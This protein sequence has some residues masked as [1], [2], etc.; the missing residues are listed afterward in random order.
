MITFLEGLPGS[1]KS[2][3]SVVHRLI[4]ALLE[5]REIVTNVDGINHAQISEL[6]GI[7]EKMLKKMIHL[8]DGEQVIELDKHF[9]PNALH[10][11]DELQNYFPA[12]R[13]P[14]TPGLSDFVTK[15]RHHGIDLVCMGQDYRDCHAL[16][17]RRIEIKMQ[18]LQLG[19]VGKPDSYKWTSYRA[20]GKG[21]SDLQFDKIQS[22]VRK[23]DPAY[24][25][26][27]ASYVSEDTNTETYTDARVNL[28][29]NKGLRYGVPGALLVSAWAFVHLLGF[30]GLD[31]ADESIS[32][33]LDDAK[34][35]AQLDTPRIRL[36]EFTD[37]VA[38]AKAFIMPEPPKPEYKDV[39]TESLLLGRARVSAIVY[40]LESGRIV[41]YVDVLDSAFHLKERFE[42]QEIRALGYE[43][44]FQQYGVQLIRE[45]ATFVIRP[46]PV[47]A[48]GRA[49]DQTVYQF[50]AL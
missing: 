6:T 26:T 39:L 43:V 37:T 49:A 3:E 15:H 17:R 13:E 41:G 8:I 2:Y 46:W 1:G 11:I 19:A 35:V 47:D 36:D 22:G 38:P 34:T 12:R 14:L 33:D 23:Y 32:V 42:F 45:E 10:I 18:F 50:T 48:Y 31:S 20:K 30:F 27:Y 24:F 25:G 5:G 9:V 7:P 44:K 16:W 28:W 21:A 40:G 4:P 29:N